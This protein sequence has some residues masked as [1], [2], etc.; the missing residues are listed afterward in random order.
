MFP[1]A[2]IIAAD[3]VPRVTV[4][5]GR[6]EIGEGAEVNQRHHSQVG[7]KVFSYNSLVVLVEGLLLKP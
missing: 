4:S 7:V 1:F 5:V 2:Q 6:W 3:L